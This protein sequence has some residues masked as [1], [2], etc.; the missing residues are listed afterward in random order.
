VRHVLRRVRRRFHALPPLTRPADLHAILTAAEAHALA[1]S[2]AYPLS[3]A[4]LAWL[5]DPPAASARRIR[6]RE[7]QIAAVVRD[8]LTAELPEVVALL[9]KRDA[10]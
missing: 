8:V 5:A 7:Q 1:K 2:G 3:R 6:R 10:Q 9:L 4:A